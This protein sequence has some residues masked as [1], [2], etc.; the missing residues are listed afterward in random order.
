L[1]DEIHNEFDTAP[2]RILEQALEIINSQSDVKIELQTTIVEKALRL[3]SL[4]FEKNALV[5]NLTHTEREI[6]RSE[7][8]IDMNNEMAHRI[9]YYTSSYP[10]LKFLPESELDRICDKYGLVYAPVKHYRM[11]VPERI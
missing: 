3:K 11:P 7:G 5:Y 8:L 9:G 10:F 1:I 2:Q 6:R 4:G